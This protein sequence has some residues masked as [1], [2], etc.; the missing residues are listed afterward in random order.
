MTILDASAVLAFVRSE[1]GSETVI[2]VIE[3]ARISAVNLGEIV[4]KMMDWRIDAATAREQID[5]LNLPV[6]PFDRELA[7]AAG[8]LRA[9]TSHL[10][11]SFGD[12]ACLAT[13]KAEGAPVMT[14]DRNWAKLELDIDIQVIR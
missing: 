2:S 10:G 4:S 9:Q 13:A 7:I 11:L 1:P 6:I 12:R 5:A 3:T 14:T 8:L